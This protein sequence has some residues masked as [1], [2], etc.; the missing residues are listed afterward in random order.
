MVFA[1]GQRESLKSST[2]P[3]AHFIMFVFCQT[4]QRKPKFS[5]LELSKDSEY[6]LLLIGVFILQESCT[7]V[8]YNQNTRSPR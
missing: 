5:V 2:K 8:E 4:S 3:A 7:E 6:T 1:H